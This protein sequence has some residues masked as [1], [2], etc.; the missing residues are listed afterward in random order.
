VASNPAKWS[1][2]QQKLEAKGRSVETSTAFVDVNKLTSHFR[3][4]QDSS[5]KKSVSRDVGDLIKS[6]YSKDEEYAADDPDVLSVTILER[7]DSDSDSGEGTG[8]L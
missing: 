1:E 7:Y 4:V 3:R 6:L 2:Y 5:V 8:V